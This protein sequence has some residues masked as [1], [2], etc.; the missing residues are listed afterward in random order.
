MFVCAVCR[1]SC[2]VRAELNFTFNHFLRGSVGAGWARRRPNGKQQAASGEQRTGNRE[3]RAWH[4]CLLE[5]LGAQRATVTNDRG[6]I[7]RNISSAPLCSRPQ[8]QASLRAP[9]RACGCWFP[10][11][12]NMRKGKGA[13][14]EPSWRPRTR[15][16]LA[17][18]VPG[19][20]RLS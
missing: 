11:G 18:K 16:K 15:P 6:C 12:V 4:V 19:P 17:G 20:K 10:F 14:A 3:W 2:L 8:S 5:Q 1:A 7:T 13:Q 9:S